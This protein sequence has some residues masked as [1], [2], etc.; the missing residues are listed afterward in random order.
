[1]LLLA[2][3]VAA[4]DDGVVR[5]RVLT[6]DGEPVRSTPVR[7][8]CVST[9]ESL[10]RAARTDREGR[11]EIAGLPPGTY[12]LEIGIPPEPTLSDALLERDKP[13][14]LAQKAHA[15]RAR[16]AAHH[17][18]RI[19][20]RDGETTDHDIRL[21]G[22][23]DVTVV[24]ERG[25]KPVIGTAV[26]LV[27]FG[28]NGVPTTARDPD[29]KRTTNDDGTVTFPSTPEGTYGVVLE[30]GGWTVTPPGFDIAGAG[31]HRVPVKLGTG[32]IRMR[33]LDGR[34]KPVRAASPSVVTAEW[35][36][37]AAIEE[38]PSAN[39]VYT[40]PFVLPG[41]YD[42]T[43]S[44]GSAVAPE[45]G[46]ELVEGAPAAEVTVKLPPTGTL[47]VRVVR[48]GKPAEE[49]FVMLDTE[50][51]D[52]IEQMGTTDASGR[53]RFLHLPVG[54]WT[55][56]VPGFGEPQR[57]DVKAFAERTLTFRD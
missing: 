48:G 2:A 7:A 38:I 32:E 47:V 49:A 8:C 4:A 19:E 14:Y 6:A 22:R 44:A 42:A 12:V 5:G 51:E 21:P 52:A 11:F 54:T 43:A 37:V 34:G 28:A 13:G 56:A 31:P 41:T 29:A 24:I 33:V 26:A 25:G 30:I 40:I 55:V 3:W 27:A 46:V 39:G 50:S 10:V 9:K 53:A 36:E 45:V 23:V 20:V 18:D 57:V 1:L 16:N 35:V 17:R 15:Q